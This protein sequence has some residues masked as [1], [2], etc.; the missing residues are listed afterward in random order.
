MPP[1]PGV[2]ETGYQQGL[3][4]QTGIVRG[5]TTRGVARGLDRARLECKLLKRGATGGSERESALAT[6]RR[7][8]T[9][10]NSNKFKKNVYIYIYTYIY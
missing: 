7:L 3:V 1:L 2:S 6:A 9:K 8:I 4:S 5:M 10:S